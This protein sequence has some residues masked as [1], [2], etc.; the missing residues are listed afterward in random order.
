MRRENIKIHKKRKSAYLNKTTP[1]VDAT[2]Q[3]ISLSNVTVEGLGIK[4]S[5]DVNFVNATVNAIAHWYIY[6]SIASSN[7]YLVHHEEHKKTCRLVNPNLACN[8]GRKVMLNQTAY[9][10]LSSS[11]SKGEKTSSSSTT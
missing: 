6:Q 2:P 1:K 10:R 7:W 5:K 3:I 9:S 4:L 8:D 11:L